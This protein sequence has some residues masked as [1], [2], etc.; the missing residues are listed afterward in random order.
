MFA[1]GYALNS[2]DT[3]N[4]TPCYAAWDAFTWNFNENVSYGTPW[5]GTLNTQAYAGGTATFNGSTEWVSTQMLS[6][7]DLYQ[8]KCISGW[9]SGSDDYNNVYATF[10]IKLIGGGSNC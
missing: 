6:G 4:G 2:Y 3:T 7:D 8:N 10:N 9:I 5:I 1:T